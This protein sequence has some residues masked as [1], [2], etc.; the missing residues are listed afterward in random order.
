MRKVLVVSI[1]KLVDEFIQT[2]NREPNTD[3]VYDMARWAWHSTYADSCS[4]VF[5]CAH[6]KILEVFETQEWFTCD[7][8]RLRLELCPH[9][10][11]NSSRHSKIQNDI[12]EGTRK[13]FIGHVARCS[14][15]YKGKPA[16]HLYGP[17][18]YVTVE[19]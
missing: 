1:T 13:A 9:V 16:P 8:A 19:G 2:N 18:G 5:A 6:G 10:T 14:G 17:I 4:L 3:E 15:E 7:V 11:P 12:N